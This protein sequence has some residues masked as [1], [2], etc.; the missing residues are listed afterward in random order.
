MR[1]TH[2]LASFPLLEKIYTGICSNT[3]AMLG[4]LY[5][6]FKNLISAQ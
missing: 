2:L 1:P 3:C 5:E 6:A 4:T